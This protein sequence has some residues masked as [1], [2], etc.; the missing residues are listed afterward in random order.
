MLLAACIADP[1][2]RI[3]D[4]GAGVGTVGLALALRAPSASVFLIERQA[5]LVALAAQNAER[6]GLA[7]RVRTLACDLLV[8]AERRA[9]GL[10]NGKASAVLTNPPYYEQGAVRA[11]PHEGRA[12]AHVLGAG[13]LGGWMR[14]C[15][16]LLAPGGRF[17]MIHLPQ[18]LSPILEACEGRLGAVRVMP[19]HAREG[20]DAGRII[21]TGR[22]GSRAPLALAPA[23]VVHEADGRFTAQAEA[24]H[25]G[26]ALLAPE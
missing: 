21:V 22:K 15:L 12:Q 7:E 20:E 8:P 1:G 23:F 2:E 26:E 25:R 24:I 5:D 4:A 13:G 3:I 17:A 14:A 18:A 10:A 11:S 6:N 9:A 19:V 16:A